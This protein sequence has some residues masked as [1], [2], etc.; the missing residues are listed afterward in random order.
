M[1]FKV[2]MDYFLLE[3]MCCSTYSA[4]VGS[5]VEGNERDSKAKDI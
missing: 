1:L 4:N 3:A 2:V 5:V